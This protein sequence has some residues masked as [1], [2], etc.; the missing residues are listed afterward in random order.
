MVVKRVKVR[1]L[2]STPDLKLWF[3]GAEAPALTVEALE[4][5]WPLILIG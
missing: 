1:L 5:S 3:S 4:A 2:C